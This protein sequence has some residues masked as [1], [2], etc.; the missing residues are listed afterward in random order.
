MLEDDGSA[1]VCPGCLRVMWELFS[2][3][4]DTSGDMMNEWRVLTADRQLSTWFLVSP[5]FSLTT[6]FAEF[7]TQS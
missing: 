1:R 2:T 4:A 5:L 7:Q 6:P 3:S